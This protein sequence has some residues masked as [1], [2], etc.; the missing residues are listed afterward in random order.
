MLFNLKQKINNNILICLV[1]F[2]WNTIYIIEALKMGAPIKK[3]QVDIN[4]FPIVISI[5]M[6][7]VTFYLFFQSLK[8]GKEIIS[9]DLKKTSKPLLI[10]IFTIS[11]ILLLKPI[12][13]MLSSILY[14]FSILSVFSAKKRSLYLKII[15]SIVIAVLIF[16][17]YEK[18]FAIRLPKLGGIF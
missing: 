18:I 11:Y 2:I 7:I 15:Y 9:F 17:L 5:L 1:I 12:G 8:Q 14:I 16:L 3:G 13:Y 10:I 4:F 6:Y